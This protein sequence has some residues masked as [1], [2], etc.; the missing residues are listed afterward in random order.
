MAWAEKY[1]DLGLGDGSSGAGS[2]G[3]P[4]TLRGAIAAAAAGDRVN[5]KG[6]LTVG[7]AV[8]IAN[9]GTTTAPIWWRGY[10]TNIGDCD[11][12]GAYFADESRYPKLTMGTGYVLTFTTAYT[13]WSNNWFTTART[14]AASP[15]VQGAAIV[16]SFYRC[17]FE[18]T[19]ENANSNAFATNTSAG[20]SVFVQCSYVATATATRVILAANGSVAIFLGCVITGGGNGIE[21]ATGTSS[22]NSVIGCLIHNC[23][24]GIYSLSTATTGT[25]ASLFIFGNTFYNIATDAIFLTNIAPTNSLRFVANNLF[26]TVGG[27]AINQASGGNC[28]NV[29]RFNNLC[30]AVTSGTSPDYEAGFGDWPTFNNVAEP[31]P[32]FVSTTASNADF[33]KLVPGCVGRNVGFPSGVFEGLATQGYSDIGAV[34]YRGPFYLLGTSGPGA[35]TKESGANARSGSGNAIK[36]NPSSTTSNLSYT[37]LLPVTAA[38]AFTFKFWHMI[39][40]SFNGT[41]KVTIWDT[42]DTTVLLNAEAVSL[43]DDAAY[44][45]YSATSETPTA[46]GFCRIRIDVLDGATTGDVY[47]D[48]LTV[49]AT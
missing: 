47:V 23:G 39:T 15:I 18:A 38:T 9:A 45:Q 22:G 1:C 25:G 26:S 3:D 42:D 12:G 48:D 2:A 20:G 40:A 35:V 14:A 7:S 10:N 8:T 30:H 36:F 37:F 24:Y 33:L 19:G 27:Y 16:Q 28:A 13:L 34:R 17:K 4:W 46:T 29:L 32:P 44:H 43:T 6:A 49:Q 31:N 11:P 41:V 5:I 21:Y